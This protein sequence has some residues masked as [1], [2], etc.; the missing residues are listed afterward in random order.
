MG[1]GVLAVV[2][3]NKSK[4]CTSL[5]EEPAEQVSVVACCMT[6]A[7]LQRR[8]VPYSIWLFHLDSDYSPLVS[9]VFYSLSDALL[10]NS[11]KPLLKKHV[12]ETWTPVT[13]LPCS[14]ILLC[15][16]S[17][18]SHLLTVTAHLLNAPDVY[19]PLVM[20]NFVFGLVVF[21]ADRGTVLYI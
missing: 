9:A 11:I 12:F 7:A 6:Y 19:N 14:Y 4:W 8:A 17:L 2:H 10:H 3:T 18:N 13:C 5:A 15:L 1:I 16:A 20:P 21:G